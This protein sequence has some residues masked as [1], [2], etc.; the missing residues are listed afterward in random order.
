[1][2]M[3]KNILVIF[4]GKYYTKKALYGRKETDMTG[5]TKDMTIGEILRANPEVPPIAQI[6]AQSKCV[7]RLRGFEKS[8]EFK[9]LRSS[10]SGRLFLPFSL[11]YII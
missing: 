8:K 1:M 7:R 10:A 4:W 6:S 2:L 11:R 3:H 5:V 9:E